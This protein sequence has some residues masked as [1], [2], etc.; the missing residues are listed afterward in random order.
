MLKTT[1]LALHVKRSKLERTLRELP[2]LLSDA[3][4][5]QASEVRVKSE[6][7]RVQSECRPSAVRVPSE[8][9][10]SAV[11]VPSECHLAAV[12]VPSGGHQSAVRMPYVCH[13]CVATGASI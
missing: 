1:A 11:R 6:C 4:L 8:C 10:L 13:V 12:R 5:E 2:G 7:H 9:H 3:R